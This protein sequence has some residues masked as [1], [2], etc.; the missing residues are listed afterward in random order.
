MRRVSIALALGLLLLVVIPLRDTPDARAHLGTCNADNESHTHPD[1][2]I[3]VSAETRCE[4]PVSSR[5]GVGNRFGLIGA[6]TFL[7]RLQGRFADQISGVSIIFDVDTEAIARAHKDGDAGRC[8]LPITGHGAITFHVHA[9][10]PE[11]ETKIF[12]ARFGAAPQQ[13]TPP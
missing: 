9:F 6:S 13:C 7:L 5:S 4:N 2:R 11:I 3:G 12:G 8:Y 10:P 1:G